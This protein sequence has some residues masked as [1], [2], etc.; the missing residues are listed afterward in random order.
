MGFRENLLKRITINNLV[1]SIDNTIGTAASGAKIDKKSMEKLLKMSTFV[2]HRE[3]DMDLYH[4]PLD[5]KIYQIL[6][7]DNELPMFETTVEDVLL[8]RNPTLK[9]MISV[10]NAMKILND[11]DVV[12]LRRNESLYFVQKDLLKGLDL[13]FSKK[14]IES[15][16]HGAVTALANHD[17]EG[18]VESIVLFAEILGYVPAPSGFEIKEHH[19]WGK[20][21][22]D[23]PAKTLWGPMVIY[24]PGTNGLALW[25]DSVE[26]VSFNPEFIARLFNEMGK[27]TP[28]WIEGDEVF[29][30][31]MDESLAQGSM[32]SF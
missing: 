7:L 14:D 24:N 32:A 5:D 13:T 19:I 29:R 21:T 9:E 20:L 25:S 10:R 1:R 15:M 18:V 16:F 28:Q 22:A 2:L 12:K 17:Q 3:R 27:E 6:V 26:A 11:K 31:L 8:R 30:F 23:I 4:R